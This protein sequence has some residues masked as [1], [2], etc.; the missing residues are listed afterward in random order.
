MDSIKR[1]FGLTART[2]ELKNSVYT[3]NLRIAVIALPLNLAQSF[4][5]SIK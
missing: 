2:H 1:I 5:K 4:G 3:S